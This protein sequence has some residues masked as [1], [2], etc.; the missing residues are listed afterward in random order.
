MSRV[1]RAI[2]ILALGSVAL[3]LAGCSAAYVM[4]A[5]YEEAKILWRREP[6][7]QVL[8]RADL[9]ADVRRK[10]ETV[11]AARTFAIGLGLDVDGSFGSLSYTDREENVFVLTAAK[12]TALE[13]YTWWFP[14]VGSVP[15][16][17]FFDPALARAE[18]AALQE[19][20]YDTLVRTAAAFSTLGW[21]A[22][23]LLRHLLRDDEEF[24]V[25]LVLHEVYHNTFYLPGQAAFNE[26]LA[27]FIGHRGAIAF[28][29]AHP[30][31]AHQAGE[32]DLLERAESE[33][34]DALIFGAF[35]SRIATLVRGVYA[36]AA[37]P[38]AALAAR[39]GLFTRAREEYHALPFVGGGYPSFVESPLNNA[40]LLHYLLYGTDLDLFDAIYHARDDDLQATIAFIK[41]AAK[42]APMDPF[43]AVHRASEA[44]GP[45]PIDLASARVGMA[46]AG[47]AGAR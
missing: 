38:A 41:A 13:P 31:R 36:D 26:S 16:K 5:G 45:A 46:L 33:W 4:R 27:T 10:L 44:Y 2:S 7:A 29:R 14:I 9:D 6:M 20:G 19:R 15:Y 40:V 35:V 12:R 3:A 25:D 34:Q 21:F 11:L 1:R 17:G 30:E 42:Q 22:D 43:G 24:L 28:F 37:D 8:A 47:V 23:P 18:A 39:E 32:G